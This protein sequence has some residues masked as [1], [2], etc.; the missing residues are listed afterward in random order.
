MQ[1]NST[2]NTCEYTYAGFFVRA[3]AYL[4]DMLI[5][6][7]MTL[8]IRL[9]TGNA[10]F[11]KEILFTFDIRSI[12]IYLFE[13]A[14]FIFFTYTTNATPGK[15]LMNLRVISNDDHEHLN[16]WDVIFRETVGKYL[17]GIL[18]GI[19]Y[20]MIGLDIEKR[21]LHD[22]LSDTHVIYAQKVKHYPT[23][24]Y[25]NINTEYRMVDSSEEIKYDD[26]I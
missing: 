26:I 19:G 23:N 6:F 17:S 18:A 13:A 7:V 16:L 25:K 14:Y 9:V 5:V 2:S 24:D 4:I 3:F 11:H 15:K 10:F 22:I 1:N 21:G 8:L 20:L 12:I